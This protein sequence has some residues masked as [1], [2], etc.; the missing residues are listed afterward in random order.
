MPQSHFR[1]QQ[2]ASRN[3]VRSDEQVGLVFHTFYDGLEDTWLEA[4]QAK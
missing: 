1:S 4:R 3:I 2:A